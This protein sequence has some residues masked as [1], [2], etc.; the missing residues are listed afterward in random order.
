MYPLETNRDKR[1]LSNKYWLV[2]LI[3]FI[4]RKS[5]K[6]E[7][8]ESEREYRKNINND[9]IFVLVGKNNMSI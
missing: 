2:C 3:F 4:I 6:F 1:P 7:V 5:F 9:V 8:N